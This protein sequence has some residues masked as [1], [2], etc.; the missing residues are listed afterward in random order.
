MRPTRATR[1][2]WTQNAAHLRLVT[3]GSAALPT[4]VGERWR[5]L[6][7]DYP[8]ERFGMTE[9]G[10]GMTNPVNGERRP[11]SCGRPLPGMRIRIVGEDGTDVAP[12]E[13]GEIWIRGP[14]VFKGYDN[15]DEATREAFTDGWFKSGDTATWLPG[16]YAK[17]LG[18]TSVDILKSGGYKLSALE[19]EEVLREHEAVAD[20]AVVGLPDETWGEIAVAAVI[21]RPGRAAEVEE[22]PLAGLGQG[23]HCRLQGAEARR[24]FRCAATQSGRQGCQAGAGGDCP[25]A[26]WCFGAAGGRKIV[27][28]TPSG[29]TQRAGR[30]NRK[31]MSEPNSFSSGS[32]G[33]IHADGVGTPDGA[34]QPVDKAHANLLALLE[35]TDDFILFSDTT[36]SP[37]FFNS[38]YANLMR[39]VLG[40]EM[41][42]GLKPHELLDDPEVRAM[43]DDFHRRVL[44]GERFTVEIEQPT[45]DGL[46]SF[47]VRYNPVLDGG[48]IVGFSEF[49][50]DITDRKRA[51]A[52]LRGARDRLEVEVAERTRELRASESRFRA[53][54]ERS[55]DVTLIADPTRGFTYA[56]PSVRRYGYEPSDLLGQLPMDLVHPADLSRVLEAYQGAADQPGRPIALKDMRAR[57]SSGDYVVFEGTVTAYFDVPGIDG[58]VTNLRDVTERLE[59]ETRLRHSEKLDAIGQLAGGMAHDF[60]NQL[61]GILAAADLLAGRLD[62]PVLRGWAEQIAQAALRSADLTGKL[63]AFARKGQ[64]RREVVDV[65]EVL[66]DAVELLRRSIDK[67]IDIELDLASGPLHALGDASLLQ[68]AFLNLALN[69]RDAMPDG[70]TLK[71]GARRCHLDAEQA[72]ALGHDVEPGAYVSVSVVDDGEGMDEATRKHMFEPFFTT[73]APGK[74]TGMGL[75][76]VYGTL[77]SHG[78]GIAVT[79]AP[80]AGTSFELFLPETRGERVRRRGSRPLESGTG[81][82]RIMVVE[83]EPVVRRVLARLVEEL[84]HSATT[85]TDGF[86]A[87][88]RFRQSGSDIDL[89]ILD[90]VMPKQ[91]GR[92]TF[93][94]LRELDP[95][96]RVLISSGFT[97]EG[98]AQ[99]LLEQGAAGFLQKP[100]D[101]EQLSEAIHDARVP[102]G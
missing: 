2:R 16:G 59:L 5:A 47:E 46:R 31:T 55:V 3:S 40:I 18:R 61:T 50:R 94:A 27:P 41:R 100:F 29:S 91:N 85:C 26:A 98:G 66:S 54:T 20:V 32:G 37:L 39:H 82:L 86:E 56:S 52:A 1:A 7:G 68:N 57:T 95:S 30:Y 90:L 102:G 89:V 81:G 36:G 71:L 48:K 88:E 6:T 34:T 49:S 28:V 78:G 58:L 42:P 65:G 43:W 22:E 69:A 14:G 97:V 8:L 79:T 77:R 73:K 13:S 75:A 72:R 99:E 76:S 84:G 9:I 93:Y 44:S 51:E 4:T 60:N 96:V 38:A 101:L 64:Y 12:G 92:E 67:R 53:L 21:P 23:A 33:D 24:R 19:I 11:G 63:L 80:G 70:G 62:E 35:N 17:I 74:G 87:V 45:P 15:N 25:G 10:V 83:D